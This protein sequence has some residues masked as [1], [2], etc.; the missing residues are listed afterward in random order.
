MKIREMNN[1][2]FAKI[3]ALQTFEWLTTDDANIMDTDYFN[4]HSGDK[5]CLGYVDALYTN[6][7]ETANTTLAKIIALRY[8]DKWNSLYQS[9][10]AITPNSFKNFEY[11]EVET[12]NIT[13][14]RSENESKEEHGSKSRDNTFN[15]SDS[16]NQS[17]T[18]EETGNATETNNLSSNQKEGTKLTTSDANTEENKVYGFN[19]DVSVGNNDTN[20]NKTREV[21]GNA[22]ENTLN[23]TEERNKDTSNTKNATENSDRIFSRSD[24]GNEEESSENT[25]SRNNEVLEQEL[26]DRKFTKSGLYNI[27]RQEII[28]Q[29][30][31]LRN[32]YNLY[33]II[34]EDVDKII[35]LAIY[36]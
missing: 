31:G 18:S 30:I 14:S 35:A 19:S 10:I 3:Q 1:D 29:E 13:K 12:P 27:T 11:E 24:T 5:T 7:Q 25:I 6:N 36:D 21:S 33:N 2:I 28:K 26:G 17:K 32:L 15:R 20:I 34:Y 22:D 9:L 4:I 23:T 16:D 8:K